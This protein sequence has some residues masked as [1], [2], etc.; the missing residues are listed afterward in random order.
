MSNSKIVFLKVS[1][2]T[3]IDRINGQKMDES[4]FIVYGE[5]EQT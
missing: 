4:D 1:G 2:L 5:N 3:Y